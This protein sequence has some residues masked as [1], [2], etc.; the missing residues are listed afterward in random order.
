MPTSRR[1][2]ALGGARHHLV[3]L[4]HLEGVD[5]PPGAASARR[6]L[7]SPLRS[8]PTADHESPSRVRLCVGVG[9]CDKARR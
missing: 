3:G 7:G 1:S 9:D 5:I 6:Q 2:P 4:Q 8:S